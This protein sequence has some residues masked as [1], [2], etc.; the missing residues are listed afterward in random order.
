MRDN[1]TTILRGRRVRLVPYLPLHVPRY[2]RWMQDE[3]LQR[4]TCSEPLTLAE[5]YANQLSW[6]EDASKATFIVCALDGHSANTDEPTAV[7]DL[8]AGMC[9]DVPR[10]AYLV[11]KITDD[12]DASRRLFEGLGFAVHKHLAVF[13]QTELRLPASGARALCERHWAAEAERAP[14]RGPGEQHR[15][16][17]EVGGRADAL[18]TRLC[19]TEADSSARRDA[20]SLLAA[21]PVASISSEQLSLLARQLASPHNCDVGGGAISVRRAALLALTQLCGQPDGLAAVAATCL[22]VVREL[23]SD[24]DADAREMAVRAMSALGE[25]ADCA[26][27]VGRLEDEEGDVRSAAADALVV[28]RAALCAADV[29]AVAVLCVS[30]G[31]EEDASVRGAAASALARLDAQEHADAVADL[32]GDADHSVRSAATAA[33]KR[34]GM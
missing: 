10:V 7:D 6:R 21:L 13:E 26:A 8:T 1:L 20:A 3:E 9:G 27:L 19:D 32:L 29:G 31:Q 28:L 2:H 25:L 30:H 14:A 16:Q 17:P 33:M 18:L 4:L 5:E 15:R 24:A 23:L 11:A 22:P 34:W 12:N